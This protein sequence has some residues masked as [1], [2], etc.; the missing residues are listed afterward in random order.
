[1]SA[2]TAALAGTVVYRPN[3]A[4]VK[5]ICP[6]CGQVFKPAADDWPFLAETGAPV[7]EDCATIAGKNRSRKISKMLREIR[8]LVQVNAAGDAYEFAAKAL[9]CNDLAEQFGRVNRQHRE[10]GDIP[11]DLYEERHALYDNLM[12][13]AKANLTSAEYQQLYD[14]F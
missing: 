1:M 9:G 14:A 3:N 12:A 7:C 10:H 8:E 6:V 5:E 2:L 4:S 11:W 13:F